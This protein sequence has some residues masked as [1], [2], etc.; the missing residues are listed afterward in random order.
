MRLVATT[1]P[2]AV[3]EPCNPHSSKREKS[4]SLRAFTRNRRDPPLCSGG[5]TEAKR[6]SAD[7][8]YIEE[9]AGARMWKH[10]CP[11]P[12]SH[13][14]QLANFLWRRRRDSNPRDPFGST[15]LAGERLRPLG[16]VSA[17]PS[18]QPGTE[19]QGRNRHIAR[20][21][22]RGAVEGEQT[23]SAK[24]HRRASGAPAPL[25]PAPH[26]A[27]HPTGRH[28]N[29]APVGAAHRRDTDKIPTLYRHAE[30][31]LEPLVNLA[32]DG[33]SPRHG[34]PPPSAGRNE[35]LNP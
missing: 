30:R 8:P 1:A 19:R 22:G 11:C 18:S 5:G 34:P 3:R 17:D 16:H 25:R 23:R 10:P 4:S 9:T 12:L 27:P 31:G 6:S 33:D 13:S 35:A 7:H 26:L 20:A 29:P 24:C 14:I 2:A 32:G 15:P 21:G 28:I